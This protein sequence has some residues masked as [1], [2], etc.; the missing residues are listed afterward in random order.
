[1]WCEGPLEKGGAIRGCHEGAPITADIARVEGPWIDEE[2]VVRRRGVLPG[3]GTRLWDG[4]G[5][6]AG[7][8]GTG[9]VGVGSE[10]VT[11]EC[12]RRS[13]GG[14]E[15]TGESARQREWEARSQC[16]PGRRRL[17]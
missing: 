4:G 1:M 9:G 8:P 11:Q 5:M 7:G 12:Q 17:R 10:G 3:N 2:G 13:V 15:L 16:C 14:W 6:M